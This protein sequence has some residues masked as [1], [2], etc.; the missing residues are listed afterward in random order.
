MLCYATLFFQERS[1]SLK[2][3]QCALWKDAKKRNKNCKIYE[4]AMLNKKKISE[5][6]KEKKEIHWNKEVYEKK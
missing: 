2:T 3:L 5:M 6:R 1:L 4:T